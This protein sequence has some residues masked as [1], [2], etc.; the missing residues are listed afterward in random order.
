MP[1]PAQRSRK[2]KQMRRTTPSGKRKIVAVRKTNTQ[3]KTSNRP[4]SQLKPA[5][6]K[7]KI[8]A[9]TRAKAS[10]KT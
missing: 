7:A 4:Y 9:E 5:E 6:A 3:K 1:K 2:L 10:Q 8:R